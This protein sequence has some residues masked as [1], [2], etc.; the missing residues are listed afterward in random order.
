[1]TCDE[2]RADYPRLRFPGP[3]SR[4]A[5]PGYE[6]WVRHLDDCRGCADWYQGEEVRARGVPLERYPCVHLAYYTAVWFADRA[7]A[8]SHN[9]AIVYNPRFDEFGIHLY[10]RSVLGIRYCPWCGEKTPESRRDEWLARAGTLGVTD[11]N[12]PRLPDEL[13]SDAWYRK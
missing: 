11:Q 9:V 2:F 6:A 12:D 10:D 3:A 8:G 1:M 4:L 13:K 5:E 7:D